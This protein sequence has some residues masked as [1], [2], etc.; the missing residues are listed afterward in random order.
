[1]KSSF[2]LVLNWPI[3]D[4]EEEHFCG[5]AA[6]DQKYLMSLM[7]KNVV[8]KLLTTSALAVEGFSLQKKHVLAAM[9]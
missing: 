2:T 4:N 5:G 3:H 9:I 8:R 6:L 1:M 7:E